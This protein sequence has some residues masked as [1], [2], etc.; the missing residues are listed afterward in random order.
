MIVM[1]QAH[2]NLAWDGLWHSRLVENNNHVGRCPNWALAVDP[3]LAHPTGNMPE[4]LVIGMGSGVTAVTLSKLESVKRVD[5]YDINQTLRRVLARFPAGTMHVAQ[6][7]K[8]RIVWQ[9]ARS[10]LALKTGN[11]TLLLSSPCIRSRLAPA[12]CFQRSIFRSSPSGSSKMVCSACM[13][14]EHQSRPLL[15][16]VLR[17]RSSRMC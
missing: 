13:P 16:G 11:M 3:I 12:F 17:P 9:D 4:A 15:F 8:I 14:T 10:G 1:R 7:P 6:N 2:G 5:V